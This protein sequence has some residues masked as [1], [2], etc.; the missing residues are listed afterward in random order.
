MAQDT[1]ELRKELDKLTPKQKAELARTLIDS[2]DEDL[3]EDV[4]QLW[5]DEAARRYEA[6]RRGE[7]SSSPAVEVFARVRARLRR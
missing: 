5:L 3:D 2:L 7:M 1:S 6:Y 4:E